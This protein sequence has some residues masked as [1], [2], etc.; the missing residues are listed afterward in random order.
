MMPL[1]DVAG[2]SSAFLGGI[3]E[4]PTLQKIENKVFT[5]GGAFQALKTDSG[6]IRRTRACLRK[7]DKKKEYLRK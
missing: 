3:S 5:P 7:L 6:A 2:G 1:N 4:A